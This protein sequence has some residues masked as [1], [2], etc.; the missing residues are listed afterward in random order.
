MTRLIRAIAPAKLI[1]LGEHA[2]NRG[3]AALAV[4]LGLYA[5]CTLAPASEETGYLFESS[6]PQARQRSMTREEI[7][8]QAEQVEEWLADQEYT[9]IRELVARDFF[10]PAAYVLA[11]VDR[12]LPPGLKIRLESQIPPAAGLGSGGAVFVALAAALA[13]LLMAAPSAKTIARW[14]WRG[15]LLAHGGTAS[16]LDTQ[17]SLYGGVIRYSLER[18]AEVLSCH[19]D[20]LLVVGDSGVHAPTAE[21]NARVRTWLA[22]QPTRLH[23]FHEI[24]LLVQM[25]EDCLRLG[26]WQRL[27]H[28]LNLNQL[29]LERIGVSCPPLERL[30]TAALEAGAL[31]A[32]LSGSGGGGVMFALVSPH[33]VPAVQR[34]IS[35]AGGQPLV[36]PLAVKGVRV[37]ALE[38]LA[39]SDLEKRGAS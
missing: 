15:D 6:G 17:T 1:L 32:K 28:L 22:E 34:A 38:N 5:T 35:E 3:Q 14:A 21:V 4:S 9:A 37:Q 19:P 36:V 39:A 20:L 24:G 33:S 7:L 8:Q 2:V 10:A 13:H 31:G 29:I 26:H 16:G 11:A 30:I 27:G 25:A 12:A 23:Y 18:Q